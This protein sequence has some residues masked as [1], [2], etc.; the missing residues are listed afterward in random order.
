MNPYMVYEPETLLG[1]ISSLN[2]SERRHGSWI[3]VSALLCAAAFVTPRAQNPGSRS[4]NLNLG[5]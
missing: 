5:V 1:F 3:L 4:R 2:N